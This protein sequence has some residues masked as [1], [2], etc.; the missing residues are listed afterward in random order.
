MSPFGL[1]LAILCLRIIFSC[2]PQSS[3]TSVLYSTHISRNMVYARL[4]VVYCVS[5]TF[6]LL[7]LAFCLYFLLLLSVIKPICLGHFMCE[8]NFNVFSSFLS[9]GTTFVNIMFMY[10]HPHTRLSSTN[11][12]SINYDGITYFTCPS[13]QWCMY[14]SLPYTEKYV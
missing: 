8:H 11:Y 6:S 2:L 7:N 12:N 14:D 5:H 4:C 9:K 10:V 13:M 1:V 3:T